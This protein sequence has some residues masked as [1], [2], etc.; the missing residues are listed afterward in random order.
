MWK[1]V[2]TSILIFIGALVGFY[3][4]LGPPIDPTLIQPAHYSY[5][6]S[7]QNSC[8]NTESSGK[9]GV[10]DDIETAEG[11]SYNLRTP[12]RYNSAA[13]AY[14]RIFSGRHQCKKI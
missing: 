13:P 2:I 14:R 1:I 12:S 7:A 6:D 5:P 8:Q 10:V 3:V 11:A 9:A 4:F